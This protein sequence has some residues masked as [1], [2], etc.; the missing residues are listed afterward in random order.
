M[1]FVVSMLLETA[2]IPIVVSVTVAW[3][4][5]RF[6]GWKNRA[7]TIGT[8]CG[9]V[10]GWFAQE[11]SVWVP[12][13]YLDWFPFVALLLAALPKFVPVVAAWLLVPSFAALQ[14]PRVV[15]ISMVTAV[16]YAGGLLLEKAST[17][18]SQRM[19]IGV[20]MA[21]ATACSIVL[22]QSFSLKFAQVAG[23]LAASLTPGLIWLNKPAGNTRD[24]PMLFYGLMSNLMFIGYANTSS[25]VPVW[26]FALPLL[27]PG[28][29]IWNPSSNRTKVVRG[30]AIAGLL[31]LATIP[32]LLAHPPWEGEL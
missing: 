3:Y 18:I 20:M 9:F 29:L 11:F 8:V 6:D 25:N 1:D 23:L 17:R 24:L 5:N 7:T 31:L 13:R 19:L 30:V 15:A 2:G 4:V 14:P 26:C 12:Q 10:A 32:A 16:T 21:T 28:L 22:V 27:A